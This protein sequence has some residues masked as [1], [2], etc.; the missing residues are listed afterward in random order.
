[1]RTLR[2]NESRP[3]AQRCGEIGAESPGSFGYFSSIDREQ[4]KTLQEIAAFLRRYKFL[5]VDPD[6]N[7]FVDDR[8]LKAATW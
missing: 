3:D 4:I 6:V 1:M 2:P 5:D 7:G 8:Y